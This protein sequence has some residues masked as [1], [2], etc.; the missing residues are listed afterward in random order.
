[1]RLYS[2]AVARPDF[3]RRFLR[4]AAMLAVAAMP[5]LIGSLAKA[6]E[7]DVGPWND[8]YERPQMCVDA[9]DQRTSLACSIT[10]FGCMKEGASSSGAS[11][12]ERDSASRAC[13]NKSMQDYL[14]T[15]KHSERQRRSETDD[16]CSADASSED[17][18]ITACTERI[19]SGDEKP[20]KLARD[21]FLRG[22]AYFN[23]DK[24]DLATADFKESI[25]LNP[26]QRGSY[27]Y[28]DKIYFDDD[29]YD[30][31]IKTA[32]MAILNDPKN[33]TAYRRRGAAY[34][35]GSHDLGRAYAD[36]DTAVKLN[37]NDR[38]ALEMRGMVERK[39]GRVA[40]GERDIAKA[41]TM[42]PFRV[43]Y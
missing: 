19:Q 40:D 41:H 10:M 18:L 6:D 17:T 37:P 14:D 3:I 32:N 5:L 20:V 11:K 16:G 39:L 35:V 29:R 13:W 15:Q 9:R 12:E 2:R 22:V 34:V 36:L 30:D 23:Q 27:D 26:V 7:T 8:Y 1:M 33:A 24:T 43:V 28:L 38:D 25:G 4:G 42:K 31:V 21:Y